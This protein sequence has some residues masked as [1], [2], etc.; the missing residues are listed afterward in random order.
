MFAKD[1][2]YV[3]FNGLLDCTGQVKKLRIRITIVQNYNG[4][5]TTIF[6][7]QLKNWSTYQS[8]NLVKNLVTYL[9]KQSRAYQN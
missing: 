4:L 1:G 9:Y 8:I 3:E 6:N 5:E 7:H 2:E